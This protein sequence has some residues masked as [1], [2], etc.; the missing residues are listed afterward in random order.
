MPHK[1]CDLLEKGVKIPK[2][3]VDESQVSEVEF[4]DPALDS[5]CK[6]LKHNTLKFLKTFEECKTTIVN[7]L[8]ADPRSVHFKRKCKQKVYWFHVDELNLCVRFEENVETQRYKA[9][10]FEITL[11]EQ[12][13]EG[14]PDIINK[15]N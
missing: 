13:Y 3:I 12:T 4:T 11:W 14:D 10:V 15:K 7:V 2:W 8:Q 6:I 9:I 1:E 5:L